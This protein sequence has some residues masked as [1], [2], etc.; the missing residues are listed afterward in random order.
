MDKI[1][2]ESRRE[3]GEIIQVLEKYVEAYPAEK[4]NQIVKE[5]Y[6]LLDVME[7]AW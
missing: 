6:D 3:I 2:F 5:L 7:M 4:D 1:Q